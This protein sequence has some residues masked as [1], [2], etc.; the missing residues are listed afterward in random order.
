MNARLLWRL[1]GGILVVA[2]LAA[3][4]LLVVQPVIAAIASDEVE[5]EAVT[6]QHE[7]IEADIRAMTELDLPALEREARALTTKVPRDFDEAAIFREI[8]GIVGAHDAQLTRIS[9]SPPAAFVGVPSA[10]VLPEGT[11]PAKSPEALAAAAESGLV[12]ATATISLEADPATLLEIIADL[13]AA[14]RIYLVSSGAISDS[15]TQLLTAELF[16]RPE[17][18][19]AG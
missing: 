5:L 2:I 17:E 14:P 19:V 12:V 10:A 4:W 18:P 7:L 9:I 11:A 13:S 3:G 1:V 16:F 15:S 6:T 8:E